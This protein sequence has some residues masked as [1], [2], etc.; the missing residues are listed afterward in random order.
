MKNGIMGS[1]DFGVY[2]GKC[3][4][5]YG[6][7]YKQMIKELKKQKCHELIAGIE[8][9]KDFINESDYCAMHRQAGGSHLYY[10]FINRKFKFIDEHYATLAH[11]CLHICQFYL[12]RILDRNREHEAE[13]YLHTHLM[14]QCL[15]LLRKSVK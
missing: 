3:L 5:V 13:A 4:F 15:K 7:T 2:P 12:P 1:I 6:Y 10:I 11:E 8:G 9:E 14:L